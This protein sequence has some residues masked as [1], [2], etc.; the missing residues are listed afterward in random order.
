MPNDIVAWLLQTDLDEMARVGHIRPV[1]HRFIKHDASWKPSWWGLLCCGLFGRIVKSDWL[2]PGDVV[3][4]AKCQSSF[5]NGDVSV[6]VTYELAYN[7]ALQS[8]VF[9]EATK[10]STGWTIS[11]PL[12]CSEPA[13]LG[14]VHTLLLDLS[15]VAQMVRTASQGQFRQSLT[16]VLS[17]HSLTHSPAIT[18]LQ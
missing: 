4:V 17:T 18:P 3:S 9:A 16:H 5:T 8:N 2:G 10:M 6:Y 1:H 12:F 7:G 15:K 13:G 14:D 11:G